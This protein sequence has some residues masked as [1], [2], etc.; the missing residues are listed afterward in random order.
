MKTTALCIALVFAAVGCSKDKAEDSK[1]QLKKKQT[2]SKVVTKKPGMNV[3]HKM[4]MPD[5]E[6][7]PKGDATGLTVVTST[8]SFD[9]TVKALKDAIKG[10]KLAIVFEANHQNMMKI[11]GIESKKSVTLGFGNAK[12]GNM[13]MTKEP[14]LALEMPPRITVRE[15]DD[16]KVV[17][18]FYKPSY[19]FSSYGK[20]ALVAMARKK[21]DMMLAKLASAATGTKVKPEPGPS[22]PDGA[23]IT[24]VSK[25]SFGD[26]VS[27]FKAAVKGH[28]MAIVFEANHQNMMKMIGVKSKSSVAIGFAKPQMAAKILKIDARAALEMPLRVAVR[29]LDDGKVVVLYYAPSFLFSHYNKPKL[30]MMAAKKIDKMVAMLVTMA[31]K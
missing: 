12:M 4:A 5:V 15:L 6:P 13:F 28:K 10:H 19:L 14:R 20:P 22:V 31:T 9:D 26:T 11:V 1:K 21:P 27:K 16:G 2:P 8:K 17:V 25:N 29:E 23:L 3:E 18:L 30:R 7:G 24:V